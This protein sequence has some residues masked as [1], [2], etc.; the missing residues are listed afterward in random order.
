MKVTAI[1]EA[2]D[3]NIMQVDE[4]I[5]SLQTYE[6]TLNDKPDK[7]NK[8][9]AF[10]SSTVEDDEQSE[11]DFAGEFTYA[12]ELLGRKFNKDFKRLDRK[13]RP[14]VLGKTSDNFKRSDNSRNFR[15][16]RKAKEEERPS[17]N[18]GI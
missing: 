2:Q 12:L 4:L 3:I 9:I 13:S 17:R 10:V 16:Q 18:K 7:K 15:F 1:E 14:N 6:M 8:S 11:M 5:G